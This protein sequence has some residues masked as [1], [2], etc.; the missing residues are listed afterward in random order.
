MLWG[1]KPVEQQA[2][3]GLAVTRLKRQVHMGMVLPGERLPAERKL[4]EQMGLSRVTLR[5]ALRVLEAEGYISVKRGASGGAFVAQEGPLR[6]MAL[7]RL[8]SDPSGVLRIFE[9]RAAVEPL[10]AQFSA[11]RRTPGDLRRLDEAISEIGKATNAGELRRGEAAFHLA[12]AQASANPYISSS[13]EDALASLFMPLPHGS[14]A[15][16]VAQ[17]GLLRGNV[18]DAIRDRDQA[19]AEQRM[20]LVIE[21]EQARA[22]DSKA[23]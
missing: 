20:K 9:Y 19:K 10:A 4:A 14:L 11:V 3:Y 13:I 15:E 21:Y 2:A 5:E 17:S 12:V 8:G 16:Q 7:K 23:A 6:E 18:V 22:S 1:L